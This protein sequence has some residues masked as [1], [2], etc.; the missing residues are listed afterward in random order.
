MRL[1]SQAAQLR[2]TWRSLS[3]TTGGIAGVTSRPSSGAGYI[4]CITARSA[5]R[6]SPAF[7]N[8]RSNCWP[9]ACY[10]DA[11]SVHVRSGVGDA[12]EG[13]DCGDA[14]LRWALR[15]VPPRSALPPGGRPP[16]RGFPQ[17]LCRNGQLFDPLRSPS[18]PALFDDHSGHCPVLTQLEA[19]HNAVGGEVIRFRFGQQLEFGL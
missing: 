6:S 14:L 12:V 8:T 18:L 1:A 11:S 2:A 7:T 16:W 13:E 15:P 10:G 3:F 19:V 17:F 9:T 4:N 5:S